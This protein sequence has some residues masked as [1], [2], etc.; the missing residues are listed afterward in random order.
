MGA[1]PRRVPLAARVF[2]AFAAAFLVAPPAKSEPQSPTSLRCDAGPVAKTFAKTLWLVYGCSDNLTVV[3]L[4]AP[5]NP[6]MPFYFT[7]HPTGGSYRLSG[8]GTGSKAVT[9]AA[10]AE[11]RLLT[12]RDILAL[13]A[14]TQ[15]PQVSP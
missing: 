11:L 8:E 10:F 9:D 7:F 15:R 2:L 6:A 14:E 4:T 1:P 5:G 12:S 13:L 3:V